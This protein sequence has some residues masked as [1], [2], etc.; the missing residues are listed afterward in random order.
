MDDLHRTSPAVDLLLYR[1]LAATQLRRPVPSRQ[2]RPGEHLS[3]TPERRAERY[4]K[5]AARQR[6]KAKRK[7]SRRR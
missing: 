3:A 5:K 7:Q 2:Q 4:A 1:M 6:K